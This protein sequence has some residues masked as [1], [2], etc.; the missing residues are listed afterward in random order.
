M[1]KNFLAI[2]LRNFRRQPYYTL[3]NILGLTIGITSTLFILLYITAETRYDKYHEKADRIYRISSDVTEPDDAFRWAVTQVPLAPQ[4]KQ[5]YPEVEAVV[6]FIPN[7]RTQL[8]RGDRTFFEEDVYYAD[9]TV[10]EVFDFNFIR[11]DGA[12]ALDEPNSIVLSQ[13]TAERIFGTTNPVGEVLKNTG[14]NEYAVTGVY[15]DVS[16]YSHL[17]PNA[18]ISSSSVPNLM[19]PSAQSWGGF[20]I[21]SYVLLRKGA[22]PDAFESKLSEVIDK[23]VAVIFDEFDIKIKYEL[24]ALPD[25]HLY[26]DFEGE[27]EPTGEIGFLYIFGAVAFFILFLACINYMNLSTARATKRATEVGIRKVI[28]SDRRQLIGQ[29]LSESVLFTVIALL[30]SYL[31]VFLLLPLFNN[32]FELDLQRNLLWSGPVLLGALAVV[33]VAGILGGSYPA[34]YLSA[35]QPITVLK[36]KL[37]GKSGNPLLR[38]GLVGIQFGITIFMLI[39][40]GVIYD[41]MNYLRTK[42]LGF[43]KENVMTFSLQGQAAREKYPLIRQQLLQNTKITNVGSATTT[44]GNGYGKSVMYVETA[45]GRMTS[46]GVDGYAV[47]FDYFPTLGADMV[48]GRNF[49]E[50]YGTDSTLAILVN[51]AMVRRMNWNDPIGK[52]IQTEAND[53]LPVSTVVGVVADF[54]QRSLYEPIGALIFQPNFN[55]NRVHVRIQPQDAS[56]LASVISFVEQKWQ[57]IFPNEPFEYDFV[58]TAFMELYQEDQIR[59]RIFTLFSILMIIVACLGLLGLASYT[60]EQRTKEIGVRKVLGAETT[61]ILYLLT[62]NYVLLVA[63]ATI[64]AFLAAWYFMRRWLATFSYHADMNYWLYGL[65]FAIVIV[66]TLLTTGFHA[67]KAA[68][69][70]PVHALKDE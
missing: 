50:S 17:I 62:R 63:L 40:T 9:S 1:I 59:A 27:P 24:I 51:E 55:N 41:Q 46:L 10:A 29:F 42:N 70:N 66:L 48:E 5:D 67:I 28:G 8:L 21:Y 34:F 64:P 61:D 56:D 13:T 57:E 16:N 26:S 44:P 36:G 12:S 45:E 53:T 11:G 3:L 33:L 58:D 14:G 68:H 23:Y 37:S 32:T 7:G 39:G 60:A 54:H 31:L 35:F 49:S 38:K 15:E 25:I 69:K 47:D 52:K 20:G 4:L 22:S 30:V 65:A 43:D 6:R 18:M 2:A 19:D